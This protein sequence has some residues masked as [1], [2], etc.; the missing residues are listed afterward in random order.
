MSGT[1][2]RS[3]DDD[4]PDLGDAL[5]AYRRDARDVPSRDI[6][7][8]IRAAARRAVRS[9]PRASVGVAGAD[10]RKTIA[11]WPTW[12]AVAATVVL[13]SAMVLK[14]LKSRDGE[15]GLG[16]PSSAKDRPAAP[17]VVAALDADKARAPAADAR[18]VSRASGASEASAHGAGPPTGAEAVLTESPEAAGPTRAS[19]AG[20]VRERVDAPPESS[21]YRA[22]PGTIAVSP[23]RAAEAPPQP[24]AVASALP[25][26]VP[27]TRSGSAAT[28]PTA[29]GEAPADPA[30]SR[31]EGGPSA[32]RGLVYRSDSQSRSTERNALQAGAAPFVPDTSPTRG[33]GMG[34][35]ADASAVQ[36]SGAAD[37]KSEGRSTPPAR[38]SASKLAA[39]GSADNGPEPASLSAAAAPAAPPA[40]PAAP[41]G[42]TVAHAPEDSSERAGGESDADATGSERALEPAPRWLERIRALRRD[43][44]IDMARRE[45]ERF[46]RA[47]PD[48]PVADGER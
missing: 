32:E 9:G 2:R 6:D 8:A 5:R 3:G 7:Q 31:V 4:L 35:R 11:R 17:A 25:K 36:S 33:E 19:I 23:P 16:Q 27:A 29:S 37:P 47:Y 43:G 24:P 21:D 1:S 38:R 30:A 18:G 40:A 26:A 13:A 39:A 48:Y 22:A 42:G 45:T 10:S 46:K 34:E 28:A 41:A 20:R 12:F 14:T 15:V 44:K